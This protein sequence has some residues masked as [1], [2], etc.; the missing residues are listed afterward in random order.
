MTVVGSAYDPT[1]ITTTVFTIGSYAD[2]GSENIFHCWFFAPLHLIGLGTGGVKRYHCQ[3]W[4][5]WW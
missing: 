5:N 2:P 4:R 3:F 1:V